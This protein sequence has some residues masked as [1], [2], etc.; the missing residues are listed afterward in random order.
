V[1]LQVLRELVDGPPVYPGF[2]LFAWIRCNACLQFS[3]SQTSSIRRSVPARLSD[4]RCAISVSVPCS[5]AFGASLL[6]SA[7]KASTPC[8]GRFFCRCPLLS[9]AAYSPFPLFP[10]RG[11]VRAFGSSFPARAYLVCSAFRRWSASIASPTASPT[12]PSADFCDTVWMNRFTLRHESV[13]CR[14]SPE[15]SSTA[16]ATQPPDLP[17]V[18]LMDMG[19]A[20]LA[21]LAPHRRP[22]I[23]FL[24][25]GSRL[26]SALLSGPASRRVLFHLCASLTLPLHQF[27]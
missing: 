11:T 12:L 19:F 3:S 6:L 10:L 7:G 18:S 9:R 14:R 15:L 8:S 27:G 25:I 1:L 2:P 26:C 20:I 22:R 24:F 23:R 17:P 4:V 21:P 16:F 5:A 13:T